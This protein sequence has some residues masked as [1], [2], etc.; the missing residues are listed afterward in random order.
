MNVSFIC[1]KCDEESRVELVAGS[2]EFCCPH[3]SRSYPVAPDAL[4]DGKLARCLVCSCDELYVRKDFSQRLGVTIVV[5]GIV[6]S[7]IAWAFHR[8]YLT[9][10]IL[11]ATALIDVVLYFM[12]GN[13][14]QCYR[15][16]SEYRRLAG[17][18]EHEAFSLETHER[19]R[20]QEARLA[21]Q[22][23]S[24]SAKARHS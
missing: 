1:R 19:Y 11:F 17:L 3:C 2:D 4:A 10:G 21:E 18:D 15:C 5:I 6:A 16:R 23:A 20:Q 13:V 12:V 24:Q 9:F 8:Q 7:S 22:E 14:L